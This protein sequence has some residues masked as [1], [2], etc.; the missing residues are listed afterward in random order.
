[1]K[2]LSV[3]IDELEKA[4][5]I[6]L[7]EFRNFVYKIIYCPIDNEAFFSTEDA[8]GKVVYIARFQDEEFNVA[9]IDHSE[10]KELEKCNFKKACYFREGRLVYKK[11]TVDEGD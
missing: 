3:P 10:I 11:K 6:D 1:M 2:M 9:D 5:C 8:R 4:E 7:Y